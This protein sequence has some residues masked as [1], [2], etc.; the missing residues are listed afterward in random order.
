MSSWCVFPSAPQAQNVLRVKKAS[1]K[2][3]YSW[4]FNK[5][6]CQMLR[7]YLACGLHPVLWTCSD[8]VWGLTAG[9]AGSRQQSCPAGGP[10]PGTSP[11]CVLAG[12]GSGATSGDP[13]TACPPDRSPECSG[14][15]SPPAP[16]RHSQS[17]DGCGVSTL[18]RR[19]VVCAGESSL[20]ER[21]LRGP[22]GVPTSFPPGALAPPR[23]P[24]PPGLLWSSMHCQGP[25]GLLLV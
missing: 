5:R 12:D 3:R 16:V 9:A 18:P 13:G 6:P 14:I 17:L 8:C 1:L 20:S 4:D 7:S 2:I 23:S 10:W 24:P 11:T 21:T 22:L 19:M 15:C 25:L